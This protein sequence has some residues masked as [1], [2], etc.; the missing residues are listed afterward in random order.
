LENKKVF[1]LNKLKLDILSSLNDSLKKFE[2]IRSNEDEKKQSFVESEVKEFQVDSTQ[3]SS[4][5]LD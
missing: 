5:L 1:I 3:S 4:N 2:I